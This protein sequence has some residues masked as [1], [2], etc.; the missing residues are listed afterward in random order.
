MQTRMDTHSVVWPA[1]VALALAPMK[2]CR[3]HGLELLAGSPEE[4]ELFCGLEGGGDL[5]HGE[6]A[7]ENSPA[8][9][10]PAENS[11]AGQLARGQNSPAGNLPAENS[12]R[13]L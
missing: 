5:A 3:T 11:P 4:A 12:P 9:N 2:H 8:E 13:R 1:G 10:S 6:L 7:R